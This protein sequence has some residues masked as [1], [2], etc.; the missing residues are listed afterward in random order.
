MVVSESKEGHDNDKATVID[1]VTNQRTTASVLSENRDSEDVQTFDSIV[2]RGISN[3]SLSRILRLTKA[4]IYAMI[5]VTSALKIL[6][7]VIL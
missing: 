6:Y 2:S 5:S 7:V 1:V 3:L 4:M